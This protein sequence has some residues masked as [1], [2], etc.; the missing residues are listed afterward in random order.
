MQDQAD[1]A[2]AERISAGGPAAWEAFVAACSETLFRVVR[3]F[4]DGYDDRMDVYLFVCAKLKE[5]DM[6]RLRAYRF[7]PDAPCR[8]STW[9]SVVARNL[10]IDYL[11]TQEGRFRPFRNVA[12]LTGIDRWV[13]DYHLRD[14][15]PLCEVARR[16]ER[17]HGVRLDDG[18]LAE[19]AGRLRRQLSPSQR[20]RLLARLAEKRGELPLDPVSGL[21]SRSD[22]PVPLP[23]V[24][25]DPERELRHREADR[26][27]R[28]AIDTVSPRHRLALALR[29]R[30]G[31]TAAEVASVLRLEPDDADRLTRE[32]LARVRE[33]LERS[34][35]GAPDFE[36]SSL[37]TLW[38]EEAA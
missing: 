20:W 37:G 28:G 16:L 29:Y 14:G 21:A 12:R 1:R 24:R 27:L 22:G 19:A 31:L 7:R 8:F 34:G 32:G 9:L 25:D 6:R 30:D 15:M 35:F 38:P 36:P 2:L 33:H 17:E 11:R 13:F 18:V 3:L 5:D 23:D 4:A 26:A 10:A